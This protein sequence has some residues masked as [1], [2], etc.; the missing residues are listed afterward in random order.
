MMAHQHVA[1][2]KDFGVD[3]NNK[4]YTTEALENLMA[5]CGI[6]IKEVMGLIA[7]GRQSLKQSAPSSSSCGNQL[8]LPSGFMG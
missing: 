2:A 4:P 8:A 6:E 1:N 3:D 7:I 5:M